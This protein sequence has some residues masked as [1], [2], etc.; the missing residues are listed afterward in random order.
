MQ[1][2]RPGML[3]L[4]VIAAAPAVVATPVHAEEYPWCAVYTGRGNE[5]R[6]CGFVTYQQCM[7]TISGVGGYCTENPA[8]PGPRTR[9]KR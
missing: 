7:A 8:Y 2:I 9:K 4:A 1:L 5:G 6:N 3:V